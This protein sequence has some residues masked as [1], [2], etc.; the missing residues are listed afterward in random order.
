MRLLSDSKY[1]VVMEVAG[2]LR[3]LAIVGGD[4]VCFQMLQTNIIQTLSLLIQN[5]SSHLACVIQN[6]ESK[7]MDIK[8][9]FILAEQIISI[10][11]SLV[12]LSQDAL[13][14]CMPLIAFI[15]EILFYK[16]TPVET[17]MVASQCMMTMTED[18][19]E[20][21]VSKESL[22]LI[23]N[24]G[25]ESYSLRLSCIGILLNSGVHDPTFLSHIQEAMNLDISELISKASNVATVIQNQ[26]VVTDTFTPQE[27]EIKKSMEKSHQIM[28]GMETQLRFLQ[29]AMELLSD[30]FYE[31][32]SAWED[33]HDST[34]DDIMVD[35]EKD[36]SLYLE[37]F[38]A[39]QLLSKMT[40]I[41]T[42]PQ[43]LN[44][45]LESFAQEL[46]I[47]K[48][49][50]C[51]ALNNVCNAL[52]REICRASPSIYVGLWDTLF[53]F[54]S[55][56]ELDHV[57]SVLETL[58]SLSRVLSVEWIEPTTKQIQDLVT[59]L[60][61]T[62]VEQDQ[63]AVIGIL[64]LMAQKQGQITLNKVNHIHERLM[65][66]YWRHINRNGESN[67]MH[68]WTQD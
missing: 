5:L 15:Q 45:H 55:T 41:L 49:R 31:H 35:D 54:G 12:E 18:N 21:H 27:L 17:R 57:S 50:V 51:G 60:H 6:K 42:M 53:V 40:E 20:S 25:N 7:E 13:T 46:L 44:P 36:V 1:E 65:I 48:M 16:D 4:D 33:L 29:L 28:E 30:M 34:Q 61:G 67:G 68:S 64:G 66:D 58:W 32:Q 23:V 47:L 3:N 43:V 2:A 38:L 62:T 11:W 14:E 19:P 59:L 37:P 63:F 10:I 52:S 56:C 24:D 9:T 26:S 39:S 8:T 22:F